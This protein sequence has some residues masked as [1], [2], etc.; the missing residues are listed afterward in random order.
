M[1]LKLRNTQKIKPFLVN[2]CNTEIN[3]GAK[4]FNLS[5]IIGKFVIYMSN[6]IYSRSANHLRDKGK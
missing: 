6:S 2:K 4:R 5:I 1:N 3:V